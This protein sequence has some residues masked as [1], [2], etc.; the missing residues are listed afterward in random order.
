MQGISFSVVADIKMKFSNPVASG[1]ISTGKQISL[2]FY[3]ANDTGELQ[4]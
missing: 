1:F 2:A 4:V 3:S